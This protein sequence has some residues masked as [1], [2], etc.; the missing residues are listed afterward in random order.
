M[1]RWLTPA[2]VALIYAAVAAAWVVGS[3]ALLALA[4]HDAAFHSRVELVKGLGFVAVTSV[5]LYILL[6]ARHQAVDATAVGLQGS[7][8]GTASRRAIPLLI[9]L[10]LTVPLVAVAVF[11]LNGRQQEQE[12]F[13]SLKSI[14]ALKAEQ[15]ENWL[16]ERDADALALATSQGSIETAMKVLRSGDAGERELVRNQLATVLTSFGFDSV[17]LLDPAGRPLLSLGNRGA[18]PDFNAALVSKALAFGNVQVSDLIRDASGAMHIDFV[19]PLLLPE[20]DRQVPVGAVVLHAAPERFLFPLIQSWP[21]A[22]PSGEILL[23]RREGDSVLIL[24]EL[25]HRAGTALTL[26]FPVNDPALPAAAAVREGRP[27]TIRGVDHRGVPVLAAYRPVAGTAW[28]LVGKVDRK[29]VMA[30]TWQLAR[31]VGMT[32][33]FAVAL[34]LAAVRALVL[35][36]QRTQHLTL[37]VQSDR[38]LKQFYD[39]PFIGMAVAAPA[40]KR[41]LQFN[42]R[43]CAILG[44]SRAELAARTWAEVTHPEDIGTEIDVYERVLRGESEGYVMDK[45]FLRKDGAI[46]FAAIDVKCVRTPDGSVDYLVAMIQDITGRKDDDATIMRLHRLYEALGRTNSAIVRC[47]GEDDLFASVCRTAVESGGMKMAWIGLVDDSTGKVLPVASFGSGEEYLN[48]IR[49]SVHAEDP[50]GRGSIGISIRENRAFWV[51]DFRNDPVVALWHERAADYGWAASA[52]LPLHRNGVAVGALTLY[53]GMVNAFDVQTQTLLLEM[54]RDISFALDNFHKEKARQRVEEQKRALAEQLGFYL[55]VSPVI[56]YALVVEGKSIRPVWVGEN[57]LRIAGYTPGEALHRDWWHENLHLEDRERSLAA[58]SAALAG[59]DITSLE[60]RFRHK[61]GHYFWVLDAFQLVREDN[62]RIS[63]IVGAW[64]DISAVKGLQESLRLSQERFRTMFEQA[65]LGIAL[66]DSVDGHIHEVNSQFAAITGRPR[67]Q[68]AKIDW[69]ALTHP[70]DIPT[71]LENMALMDAGKVPGFTLK[72][73]FTRPDDSVIWIKITAAPIRITDGSI[74][75]RHLWMIE[76]ITES[77]RMVRVL[78]EQEARFRAL[79][80]QSIVGIFTIAAGNVVYMNPRAA[81]IFGYSVQEVVGKPARDFVAADDQE[82]E[83]GNFRRWLTE[84]AG[85]VQINFRG[86]RKDGSTVIVG[87][88]GRTAQLDGRT[89]VIG[90]LQ[91]ITEKQRTEAAIRDYIA[92]IEHMI[93][94]TVD[95]ISTIVELRDPYTAGHERRVGTLSAAIAAEMGLDEN[96]QR[97]LRIVAAVHDV[98]K[99]AVPA[100]ILSKP[101]RLTPIEYEMVKTHAQQGYEVLRG[102]ES[103]WPIAEVAHQHHERMDGSG[104]PRGLKGEEILLEARILAVADVVE[105]MGSHRPYRPTLGID[106]ALEEIEK[107]AGKLYDPHVAAACL[108]LFREKNYRIPD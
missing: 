74:G 107:N 72:K 66:I 24:N 31:W 49:L 18:M 6:K 70:D 47:A 23:V 12:A 65:P 64:H 51:Q 62:G 38:L 13:A 83:E 46:V 97:G 20:E 44:Y 5:L 25:R 15:I 37:Q 21:T 4:I 9:L 105:S 14:A 96:V 28:Y 82:R 36:Q 93:T 19:V 58:V 91:D 90:V 84:N 27:G 103:P 57:V 59:A 29:E 68:L 41:L 76:D 73:R 99:I 55:Q 54:A 7:A 80:E 78:A 75:S 106:K 10:V 63:Q 35:Q 71:V 100:E 39:L 33:L 40:T 56:S 108:R 87:V 79:A 94:G 45:R 61:D 32:T 50:Y 1:S 67:E 8:P 85:P 102:I 53:S 11:A 104:Y 48:D 22:S 81:E 77:E 88:H 86:Q 17:V 101:G 89:V 60:Y 92:R 42:D 34:L 26:S 2:A 95:A 30:P 98:G 16:A 43:L 69:Q 52:S 3:G